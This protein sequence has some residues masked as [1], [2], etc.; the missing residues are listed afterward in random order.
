MQ[1]HHS[2]IMWVR[3]GTEHQKSCFVTQ[4]TMRLSIFS[5]WGASWLNYSR[6]GHCFLVRVSKTRC[7]RYAKCWVHRHAS[8]GQTAL[9]LLSSLVISSRITCHRTSTWWF[10]TL[11]M[12]PSNSYQTCFNTIQPSD[13]QPLSASS[14][15][16]SECA[17]PFQSVRQRTS[18]VPR[19]SSK[20]CSVKIISTI[21]SNRTWKCRHRCQKWKCSTRRN[22]DKRFWGLRAKMQP[23]V[24][25]NLRSR[26]AVH[27]NEK[28]QAWVCSRKQ[29]TGLASNFP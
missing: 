9:S 10:R 2:Q 5:Q 12:R 13:P 4:I 18:K 16:F 19:R 25:S 21:N 29:G 11:A 26:A 14:I 15:R 23:Q 7:N 17:C 3:D 8:T 6:W 20:N 1:G 28:Y 22:R 27:L 24:I